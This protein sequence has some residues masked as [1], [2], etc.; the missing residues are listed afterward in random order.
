MAPLKTGQNRQVPSIPCMGW[1]GSIDQQH[2]TPAFPAERTEQL[3]RDIQFNLEI[4]L[5]VNL[6]VRRVKGWL[7]GREA[8]FPAR[9]SLFY[10]R[11]ITKPNERFALRVERTGRNVTLLAY[12]IP[13]WPP[14]PH[15]PDDPWRDCITIAVSLY[16]HHLKRFIYDI[17][18]ILSFRIIPLSLGRGVTTENRFRD[19]EK[20]TLELWT[21]INFKIHFYYPISLLFSRTETS[22]AALHS[23]LESRIWTVQK[24][25]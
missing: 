14:P 25:V 16:G 6:R 1:T 4:N 8:S 21:G 22:S 15:P 20:T 23:E 13:K 9:S 18:I 11:K 7:E 17:S 12:G 2:P 19:K 24:N 3:Y 5:D 10:E